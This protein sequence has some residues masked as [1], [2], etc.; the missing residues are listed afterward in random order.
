MASPT[1]PLTRHP[2]FRAMPVVTRS[3]RSSAMWIDQIRKHERGITYAAALALACRATELN[4]AEVTVTIEGVTDGDTDCGDW[5]V[6]AR[7]KDDAPAQPSPQGGG[8]EMKLPQRMLWDTQWTKVVNHDRAYECWDKEEAIHHAVKLAEE[9]IRGNIERGEIPANLHN[10]TPEPREADVADVRD[11][12]RYRYLQ[13][14]AWESPDK[15]CCYAVVDGK[16]GPIERGTLDEMIDAAI[17]ARAGGK[18]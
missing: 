14:A 12:G 7:K 11:A 9:Y 13:G 5:I 1:L 17:A 2:P 6:T 3:A 16:L 8:E 4:A 10:S 18:P 15:P